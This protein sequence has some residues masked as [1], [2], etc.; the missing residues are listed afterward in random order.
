MDQREQA[1]QSAFI[2][3][4]QCSQGGFTVRVYGITICYEHN[5]LISEYTWLSRLYFFLKQRTD[6]I[7]G[8]AAVFFSIKPY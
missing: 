3:S 4:I 1:A 5:V 6:S 7:S 2:K 8:S